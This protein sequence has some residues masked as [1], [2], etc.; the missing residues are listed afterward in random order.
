MCTPK[1]FTAVPKMLFIKSNQILVH[2]KNLIFCVQ[3]KK[4]KIHTYAFY[5]IICAFSGFE[6][7]LNALSYQT[8]D[9]IAH[10]VHEQLLAFLQ[11]N[12]LSHLTEKACLLNFHIHDYMTV[13]TRNP[14]FT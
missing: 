14:Q 6:V 10:T 12:K 3:I 11:T 8:L 9:D 5:C 7:H 4:K 2:K 13:L 1:V